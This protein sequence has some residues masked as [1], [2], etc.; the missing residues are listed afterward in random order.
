MSKPLKYLILFLTIKR[1]W[2]EMIVSGQ[3]KE[4]YREIK[5]YWNKRMEYHHKL[6]DLRGF[7]YLHLRNG[8]GKNS[9]EAICLVSAIE[10]GHG[11]K[12]WGAAPGKEYWVIKI[13][14]V[15]NTKN[16]NGREEKKRHQ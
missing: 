15:I 6:C 5:D 12:E 9:P 16:Y 11:K 2:F 1:K 8:Y 3:K 7:T 13:K 14:R 4:E 10:R